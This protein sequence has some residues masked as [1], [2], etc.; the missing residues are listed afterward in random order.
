MI[1]LLFTRRWLGYLTLTVVFAIVASFF[2]LWQWDR[3]EQA[4]AAIE[5]LESN[6]DREP[7]ALADAVGT[8]F[9]SSQEWTPVIV[10]GRY[11]PEDQLLVRTRPRAGQVG[12]EVLVPFETSSGARV[13]VNRG[14]VP[15]GESRDFPDILPGPPAAETTVVAR[16]KPS[17]PRLVGR[18]APEG[19]VP[20]IDL[21]TIQQILG[22]EVPSDYYLLLAAESP[23]VSPTPL[24]AT[25]PILDEGPHLSY[26]FQWFI[27]GLLAFIGLVVLLR[28]EAQREAGIEPKR[29]VKPSDSDE[30]DALLDQPVSR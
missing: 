7:E 21:A 1:R 17:E 10:S 28:Q 3:R 5:L 2:G 15:T 12:F 23:S 13:I 16:L 14:W 26:T 22:Y 19:Q 24:V 27:F 25:R 9:S 6:W 11:L 4:V 18:G 30:E 20:S 8:G 29:R